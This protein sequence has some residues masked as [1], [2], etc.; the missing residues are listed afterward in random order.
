LNVITSLPFP[1]P[2]LH[3]LGDVGGGGSPPA[4][5]AGAPSTPTAI[6]ALAAIPITL[7]LNEGILPPVLPADL[8]PALSIERFDS[9]KVGMACDAVDTQAAGP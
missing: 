4:N 6:A 9:M 8:P 3:W 1:L 2:A 7:V 5:A